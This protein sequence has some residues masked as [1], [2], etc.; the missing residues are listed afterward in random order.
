V[1]DLLIDEKIP[2]NQRDNLLLLEKDNEIINIFG[3]KKSK[4]L[5]ESKNNNILIVLREKK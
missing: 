1:K 4:T 3:V 5:L 2:L